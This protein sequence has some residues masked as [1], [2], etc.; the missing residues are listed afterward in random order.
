MLTKILF[1][2]AALFA[3]TELGI[4]ADMNVT[5]PIYVSSWTGCYIGG[6]AG[7]GVA[8]ATS[9]Y[10]FPN[11]SV[12]SNTFGNGFFNEGQSN[13]RFDN[14][15]F[16]GGGQAGCQLQTGAVIWGLEGD[17]SSF[18]NSESHAFSSGFNQ[19]GISF[20]QSFNQSLSYS[21]LAS[22][23]G[24]W[25][26]VLA[27]VYHLYATVGV[28]GV[29]TRYANATSVSI[30]QLGL[31]TEAASTTGN[32]AINPTGFV[33]GAGAEWRIWSNVIVGAEYL[34]YALASD[35]VIPFNTSTFGAL[36]SPVGLGD[37]VTTRNVDVVRLRA[38]WLFNFGH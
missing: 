26:I 25:G 35:T 33:I 23:R 3:A 8:G 9:Y 20:N 28:G 27:D 6:H 31:G 17:W 22:I 34:H 14:K 37:H 4:A 16:D 10:S 24:R 32:F 29:R 38:S 5:A 11:S 21:S 12:I 18:N 1:S 30:N 19:G 7:Y 13:Q 36:L 2:C 15:G